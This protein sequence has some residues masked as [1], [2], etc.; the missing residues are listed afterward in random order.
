[1]IFIASESPTIMSTAC[2]AHINL[3]QVTESMI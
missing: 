1:M 2:C 3:N